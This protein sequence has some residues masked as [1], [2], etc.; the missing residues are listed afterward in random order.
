MFCF[1]LFCFLHNLSNSLHLK[2]LPTTDIR[3]KAL[4]FTVTNNKN[5]KTKRGIKERNEKETNEKLIK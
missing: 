1:V 2:F 5:G 4:G 3:H